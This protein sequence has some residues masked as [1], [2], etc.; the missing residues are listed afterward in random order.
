[1]LFLLINHN[2]CR[3][4]FSITAPAPL[5]WAKII[6]C[7][8]YKKLKTRADRSGITQNWRS[9]HRQVRVRKKRVARV[10]SCKKGAPDTFL[11]SGSR[12]G[13][14]YFTGREGQNGK[15]RRKATGGG[16][17]SEPSRRASLLLRDRKKPLERHGRSGPH[18]APRALCSDRAGPMPG[19]HLARRDWRR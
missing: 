12:S 11:S 13:K 5:F 15:R 18:M 6:P 19:H 17:I 4:H 10:L 8:N 9:G 7:I 16:L 2:K 3:E 1:M 14:Q